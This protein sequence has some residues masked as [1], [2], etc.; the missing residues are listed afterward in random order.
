M[1]F[2]PWP[3]SRVNEFE[4]LKVE[5]MAPHLSKSKSAFSQ[6]TVISHLCSPRPSFNGQTP[7]LLQTLSLSPNPHPSLSLNPHCSTQTGLKSSYSLPE[8]WTS[9]SSLSLYHPFI[10]LLNTPLS[11]HQFKS[12]HA[13]FIRT[14]LF[15]DTFASSRLLKA[16][17]YHYPSLVYALRILSLTPSPD[18]FTCNTLM[19][20]FSLSPTP[21]KAIQ[22][23]FRALGSG[24]TPNAYTFPLLAKACAHSRSTTDA[25]KSH[26]QILKHGFNSNLYVNNSVIYMYA[27]CHE[28][29]VARGLFDESSKPEFCR[30]SV[31]WGVM[32]T[33]Y[34]QNSHFSEGLNLFREMMG[35]KMEPNDATLVSALSACAYLCAL[36][37]GQWIHAFLERERREREGIDVILGTALVD[38]Y[39]KCGCIDAARKVFDKMPERNLV[40]WTAMINGLSNNGRSH[41]AIDAFLEMERESIEPNDITFV[42][43]LS[44]C[45][46]AGLKEAGFEYFEKMYRVYGIKPKNEHYSCMVGLLGRLGLL[47]EAE[48]FIKTMPFDPEAS[49]WGALLGAC[50]LANDVER[51]KFVGSKLLELDPRDGSRYVMLSN[52]YAASGQWEDM[53]ELRKTMREKQVKKVAGCASLSI[54]GIIHEFVAGDRSHPKTDE[55]YSMLGELEERLKREGYVP[56]TKNVLHYMGEEEREGE[57]GLHCE[58]LAI[59]YGF[60]STENGVPLR[61]VKNLRVCGDCHLVTKMISKIYDREIV[62]RDK[63][64]F[65]HFR[66]GSCSCSDYW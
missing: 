39:A 40:S 14:H 60:I 4:S 35:A 58:R 44:A 28:I 59:A 65:H 54:N 24:I 6:V 43:V 41:E 49:T 26:G 27:C 9:G 52:I 46:N 38:M 23:Y 8:S 1:S 29:E 16:S 2:A 3:E 63:N 12:I 64:R 13:H 62:V 57:L 5:T 30:D 47:R 31:T 34:V 32:I 10:S 7:H 50:R 25:Q 11:A 22:F 61:I 18:T 51:A 55:I 15:F 20:A 53:A 45:A 56:D 66:D 19:K 36:D 33:G 21:Q 48:E 17:F 42:G 37:H